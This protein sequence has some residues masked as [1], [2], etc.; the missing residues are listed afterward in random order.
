MIHEIVDRLRA[1]QRVSPSG[2]A[3]SRRWNAA[4]PDHQARPGADA[5][6]VRHLLHLDAVQ[7]GRRAG[8]R[9]HRRHGAAESRR[10]RDGS[11]A[12]HA[13]WRRSWRPSSGCRCRRSACRRPIPPRCPTPRRR[14]ASSGSDLNGKAA[15]AAA[16]HDPR[17]PGRASPASSYGVDAAGG[18]FRTT[19]RCSVGEQQIDLCRTGAAALTRRASRYRRPATTARR[20]SQW[21]K[22]P[23]AAG[24]SSISPTARRSAKWRVDTL[25]GE[26]QLL[27]VDI[28]HD[29]G[30][31]LNPAIDL[32]Q[33]EGGFLQGVG[34]LTSEELWWN[35]PGE[36]R[37]TRRRPTRFPPRATGRRR[38]GCGCSRARPIARR[39]IYRSKAVGEPPLMLAI[40]VL[41]AIR[42]A[43][44]AAVRPAALPGSAPRRRRPRRCCAPI[45]ALR[46]GCA[47]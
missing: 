8:A 17:T 46:R 2:A 37:R 47:A 1:Q 39:P 29:V 40:S 10:H 32:G 9:L 15:Q 20:R 45:D 11:G 31:S 36:L 6:Q 28:L 38:L 18:A 42:D 5:G 13:R 23:C 24:R 7:S 35:A 12:V 16:Q 25:T 21:D 26:T 19:A 33:I 27:R 44:A 41:H 43:C 3:R 4:Q 14:A 30:T 34:W 22:R